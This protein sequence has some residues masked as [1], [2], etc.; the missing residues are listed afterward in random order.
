MSHTRFNRLNLESGELPH[1]FK[2]NGHALEVIVPFHSN[3]D[4]ARSNHDPVLLLPGY[5]EGRRIRQDALVL[6]GQLGVPAI[7]PEIDYTKMPRISTLGADL[8]RVSIELPIALA[9]YIK[10]THGVARVDS[11]SNSLGGAQLGSAVREAGELFGNLGLINPMGI[12]ILDGESIEPSTARYLWRFTKATALH[13]PPTEKGSH[14]AGPQ[15][16]G[17]IYRDV[18]AKMFWTK[19]GIAN[20][21]SVVEALA[22]HSETNNVSVL[23]GE[24]DRLFR[25][26]EI[27]KAFDATGV[28]YSEIVVG[29]NDLGLPTHE[30]AL[31][32]LRLILL[33]KGKHENL[34]YTRGKRAL[35]LAAEAIGRL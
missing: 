29:K 9:D 11:L 33:K 30:T 3:L 16:A 13:H 1:T 4:L 27:K 26:P 35:R 19:L 31:A 32:G 23:A 8:L 21:I 6:L 7:S 24:K 22:K 20:T 12:N 10:Q 2:G 14:I 17:E 5:G 18:K 28:D 15:V 34:A 25:Y